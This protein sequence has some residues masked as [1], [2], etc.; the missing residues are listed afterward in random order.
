MFLVFLPN[1]PVM[2]KVLKMSV[3]VSGSCKQRAKLPVSWRSGVTDRLLGGLTRYTV[4]FQSP[5]LASTIVCPPLPP[6]VVAV[7]VE[8]MLP[9]DS[10]L[11]F[12]LCSS[13]N[14]CCKM[15]FLSIFSYLLTYEA[16]A[17]HLHHLFPALPS[18][19]GLLYLT[20]EIQTMCVL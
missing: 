3:F 18:P 4:T 16:T 19:A 13:V 6:Q 1:W 14:L 2:S 20:A 11:I 8:E 10:D 5:R 17:V 15:N 9:P 7:T 12:S